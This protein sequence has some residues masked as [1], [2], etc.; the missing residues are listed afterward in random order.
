MHCLQPC[1][2]K[3]SIIA[4][5]CERERSGWKWRP[6]LSPIILTRGQILQY[7][8]VW[9][10]V[11]LSVKCY[12]CKIFS[13]RLRRIALNTASFLVMEEFFQ[14]IRRHGTETIPETSK[15]PST[16]FISCTVSVKLTSP[17]L[18]AYN[19][20]C[21]KIKSYASSS[22]KTQ[23]VAREKNLCNV[24]SVLPEISDFVLEAKC[25]VSSPVLGKFCLYR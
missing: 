25:R 10:K 15:I 5:S 16:T 20:V 4:S 18:C 8:S 12:I 21:C 14:N 17:L 9:S 13:T 24:N 3:Y 19:I 2:P 11:E 6:N 7:L 1:R 22:K 23:K